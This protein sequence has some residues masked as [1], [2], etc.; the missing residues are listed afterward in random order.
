MKIGRIGANTQE[1]GHIEAECAEWG[2]T[3]LLDLYSTC[4]GIKCTNSFQELEGGGV[5]FGVAIR[6]DLIGSDGETRVTCSTKRPCFVQS[7]VVEI[8]HLALRPFSPTMT[9]CTELPEHN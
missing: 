4:S 6:D 3:I 9:A 1:R 2:C 7:G 5:H 8:D